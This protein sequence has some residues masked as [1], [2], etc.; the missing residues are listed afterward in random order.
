M[1]RTILLVT[2]ALWAGPAAAQQA[3]AETAD[4]QE[5]I[6]TGTRSAGRAAIESSAPV[7]VVSNDAIEGSG[8]PDLSRALNFLQPSVNFARAATTASA[9]NTRPINALPTCPPHIPNPRFE[10]GTL[11]KSMP[12]DADGKAVAKYTSCA[13]AGAAITTT[14]AKKGSTSEFMARSP[15]LRGGGD[16]PR[17]ATGCWSA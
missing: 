3:P 16:Q 7:D 15:L 2:T 9:A 10:L 11:A 13:A 1:I 4:G 14:A 12:F 5:I 6:V 8:Y 17:R